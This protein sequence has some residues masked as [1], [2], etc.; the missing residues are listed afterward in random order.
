MQ[1]LLQIENQLSNEERTVRDTV[2]HFV[3]KEVIPLM[4]NAY[5]QG[6][7]PSKFIKELGK[8]GLLG[9][10]LPEQYGGSG[11]S[12]VE[13]GLA[14]QEL[15][16]GDSGLRSFMSV[17]SA[18]AMFPIYRFG[19]E[20]QK[21]QYLPKMARGEVIGCFGLTEPDVGSDPASMRTTAVK[22]KEGW[23]L[24]GAKMWITNAPLADIAI[25][26]AMT[27]DGVR[28]FVVD[29]ATKGFER[30]EIKHKLSLRASVTGE[31]ILQDCLVSD[32]ALLPGSTRGLVAPLS[33]LTQARFGIAWGAIGSAMYCFESAL[34]YTKGR[35]QFRKPVASY[36]LVQ[37]DLVEMYSEIVK[38]QLLNLQVGRLKDQG[39]EDF[40]MISLAKRNS[41][42]QALKIARMARNLLGANGISLDYHVIRH[43]NNL[44][45]V[46]T[47]E[48]TDNIH[49][50]I[51]GKYL[52][53]ISAFE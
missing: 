15:E 36:Q 41:C 10:T 17:Q 23:R 43:M 39:K 5:D 6:E 7:F 46:Y 12:A 9:M 44:E 2:R 1:D 4:P 13:Y 48:G 14:C 20:Q 25:V 21:E 29:K 27:D 49:T 53:G 37:K 28:G 18:L 32:D 19:S 35:I 42:Q 30:R 11:A 34:D 26:W 38:A 31:L 45:S 8:L 24:N 47:Y 22:T 33:C 3:D 16:R 51:L 40:N 52:T 50:L